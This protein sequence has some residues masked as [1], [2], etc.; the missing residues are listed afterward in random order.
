MLA[1]SFDL[2]IRSTGRHIVPSITKRYTRTIRLAFAGA[3][4]L[5]IDGQGDL[6]L[7]TEGGDVRL[8]K[9]R[10]YQDIDGQQRE[11]EGRYAL[12]PEMSKGKTQVGFQVAAYDKAKPLIID[13]VL[14][15][16]TYLGGNSSDVGL[17]IAVDSTGDAYVAGATSSVNFPTLNAFQGAF[18]SGFNPQDAFLI[19]F[20][21][22]GQVV[23]STYLGG[24]GTDGTTVH[25][26]VDNAGNAYLKGSAGSD[27]PLVNAFSTNPEGAFLTKFD[28]LGQVVY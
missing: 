24:S 25:L 18:A 19:K 12:R 5:A 21:P 26:A 8:R 4:K 17:A 1:S 23:Y 16:S 28:P 10:V 3:D 6:V 13:P 20:D 9:P 15:Y 7:K 11:I 27:F 2:Q 14:V 22:S